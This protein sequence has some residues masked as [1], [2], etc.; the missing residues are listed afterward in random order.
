MRVVRSPSKRV[1]LPAVAVGF[2]LVALGHRVA[3]RDLRGV[4]SDYLAAREITACATQSLLPHAFGE[5]L[6]FDALDADLDRLTREAADASLELARAFERDDVAAFP[7]VRAARDRLATALAAQA[8]LYA[9]LVADPDG[10]NDELRRLGAANNAFERRAKSGRR[11]LL[12]GK[13]ADWD[14]RFV[15]DEPPPFVPPP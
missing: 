6:D 14:E 5:D 11:W 1:V 10:S 15:C 8:A 4:E 12:V 3:L 7:P 13:P 2:V 9:A